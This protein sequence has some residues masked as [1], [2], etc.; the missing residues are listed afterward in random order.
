[1]DRC[2]VHGLMVMLVML[3]MLLKVLLLHKRLGC[4]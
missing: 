4:S 3:V 2:A 1:L